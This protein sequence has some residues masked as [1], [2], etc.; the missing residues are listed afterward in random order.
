MEHQR[1][2]IYA[3]SEAEVPA[4]KRRRI[5]SADPNADLPKRLQTFRDIWARQ[6][7]RI[8]VRLITTLNKLDY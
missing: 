2:Y 8:Q 4:A 1:C 6:D 5:D 7:E 3:P